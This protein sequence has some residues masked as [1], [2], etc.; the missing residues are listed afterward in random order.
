VTKVYFHHHNGVDVVL[1]S[2]GSELSLPEASLRALKEARSMMA[3]E[4]LE[5]RMDLNQRIDVESADGT[6]LHTLSFGEAVVI[7]GRK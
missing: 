6:V 5:G 7:T 2:E 3:H 4:V 1:D